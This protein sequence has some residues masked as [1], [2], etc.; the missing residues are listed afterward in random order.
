MVTATNDPALDQFSDDDNHTASRRML[1]DI[2]DRL[3]A[4][5]PTDNFVEL[6]AQSHGLRHYNV[7]D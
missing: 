7:Y 3:E 6:T 5:Y 2:D 4:E 1:D